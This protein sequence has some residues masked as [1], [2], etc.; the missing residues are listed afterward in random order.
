M[1]HSS[2]IYLRVT[3]DHRLAGE[4]QLVL[5]AQGLSPTLRPADSGVALSVPEVEAGRARAALLAYDKESSSKPSEAGQLAE[6]GSMLAGSAASATF[7]L[8][9]FC[10][11]SVWFPSDLWFERG[12]ADADRILHGELWRTVTALTLHADVV[13]AVSNA[14]AAAI[15]FG[16]VST[17]LGLGVGTA[18]VLFAGAVG[19]LANSFLYGSSHFSIGSSTAVFGAVGLVSGLTMVKHRREHSSRRRAWLPIAAGLALLGMLGSGG[20][21]VDIWA[22]LCGL[23]V[24]AVLGIATG[25][26]TPCPPGLRTQ[27]VFGSASVGVLIYSWALALR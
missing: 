27:W 22:H 24:G 15:F 2:D 14:A 18:L 25:Y 26:V 20:V 10:L 7:I 19:N 1:S 11:T 6:S 16:M 12:G 23:L 21:R 9:T 3:A 13:H 4:W 17:L 8:F 5:L